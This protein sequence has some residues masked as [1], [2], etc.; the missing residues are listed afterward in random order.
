MGIHTPPA[1]NA[2]SSLQPAGS[3]EDRLILHCHF[4]LV[5]RIQMC[6]IQSKCQTATWISKNVIKENQPIAR[7]VIICLKS[8]E[9]VFSSEGQREEVTDE[10]KVNIHLAATFKRSRRP[11]CLFTRG[12]YRKAGF[13]AWMLPIQDWLVAFQD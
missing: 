10:E 5:P 12:N 4:S 2:L 8:D 9:A 1:Y 6:K 11:Y 13:F 7:D 3:A